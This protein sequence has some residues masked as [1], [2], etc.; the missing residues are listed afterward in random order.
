MLYSSHLY[1][2]LDPICTKIL[3]LRGGTIVEDIPVAD[4]VRLHSLQEELLKKDVWGNS[5]A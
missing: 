4:R 1:D 3:Q 2:V 5:H